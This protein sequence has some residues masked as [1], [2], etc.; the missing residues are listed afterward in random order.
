MT[1][2]PLARNSSWQRRCEF[3]FLSAAMAVYPDKGKILAGFNVLPHGVG[4]TIGQ[5]IEFSVDKMDG[6]IRTK[7]WCIFDRIRATLEDAHGSLNDVF[8]LVTYFRKL[9]DFPRHN[10]VRKPFFIGTPP[11]ST[12]M[13][14]EDIVV[15]V[16]T[17]ASLP[18]QE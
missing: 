17:T 14:S 6:P 18:E 7:T 3:I 11:V 4:P 1:A 10:S 2:Q 8:K 9:R 15:E 12:M 13:P 16:E 5:T